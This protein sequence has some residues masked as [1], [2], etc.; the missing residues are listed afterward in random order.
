[1][2]ELQREIDG[3]SLEDKAARLAEA[4]EDLDVLVRTG[5]PWLLSER[6]IT[7]C[8]CWDH[9]LRMIKYVRTLRYSQGP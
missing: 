6:Y 3:L 8:V 1:M 9:M 5:A 4:Y 7:P 2:S